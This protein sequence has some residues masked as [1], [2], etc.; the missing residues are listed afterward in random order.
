MAM[1]PSVVQTVVPVDVVTWWVTTV[2][3][4]G[5]KWPD[6]ARARIALDATQRVAG[7]AVRCTRSAKDIPS[8]WPNATPTTVT[9]ADP[10]LAVF[11][12]ATR[13]VGLPW[14]EMVQMVD[15][16]ADAPKLCAVTRT[17]RVLSATWPAF[18]TNAVL[19]TH[20]EEGALEANTRTVPDR[21]KKDPTSVTCVAPVDAALLASAALGA[22]MAS[23]VT[24]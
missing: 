15:A 6:G 21:G 12:D 4:D 5:M 8:E 17:V 11:A 24:T 22:K 1:C 13:P 2:A 10:V 7:I 23:N 3:C 9:C 16:R 20:R 14:N 19:L 18:P